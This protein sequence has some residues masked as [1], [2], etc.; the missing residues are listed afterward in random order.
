MKFKDLVVL[1]CNENSGWLIA[2]IILIVFGV[3][4]SLIAGIA[5]KDASLL[6]QTLFTTTFITF[7]MSAMILTFSYIFW[8]NDYGK[9]E[10][11]QI[12]TEDVNYF[13][14]KGNDFYVQTDND[15][16]VLTI[17]DYKNVRIVDNNKIAYT[18]S[19]DGHNTYMKKLYITK[20]NVDKLGIIIANTEN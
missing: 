17:D 3:L 12:Y 8:C 5:E 2:C 9:R 19:N 14:K 11:E 10:A 1:Y 4:L 16:Y 13:I 15:I 6:I 18:K 20:D 7:I